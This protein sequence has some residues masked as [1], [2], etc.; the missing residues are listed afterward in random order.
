MTTRVKEILKEK[1]MTLNELA[2]ILGVTRGAVSRQIKGKMLIETAERIAK[3]LDV[4]MW[5]LFADPIEV[6][7]DGTKLVCPHCGKAIT[8]ELK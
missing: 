8:V 7:E 2:E 5:Q 3:A 1:G 6:S 4:P